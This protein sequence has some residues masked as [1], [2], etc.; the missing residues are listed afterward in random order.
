[1]IHRWLTIRFWLKNHCTGIIVF[2]LHRYSVM[3][4]VERWGPQLVHQN[5]LLWSFQPCSHRTSYNCQPKS[6]NYYND[7]LGCNRKNQKSLVL[8]PQCLAEAWGK[9]C[10][11]QEDDCLN[12]EMKDF[13][14]MFLGLQQLCMSG[15]SGHFHRKLKLFCC[16]SRCQ[17]FQNA[18]SEETNQ[19]KAI[20]ILETCCFMQNH[21]DYSST[22]LV[23]HA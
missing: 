13:Q 20:K 16:L 8:V 12:S 3:L 6:P 5:S 11:D 4:A 15:Y 2:I 18:R 14:G 9:C 22:R 19:T 10:Q 1:M 23:C 21:V 17:H 7:V